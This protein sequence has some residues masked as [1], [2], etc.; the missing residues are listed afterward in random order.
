MKE[1][2]YNKTNNKHKTMKL[3][4]ILKAV[5]VT[6]DILVVGTAAKTLAEKAFKKTLPSDDEDEETDEDEDEEDED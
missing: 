5:Q 1:I 6:A 4:K 3:K 2:T